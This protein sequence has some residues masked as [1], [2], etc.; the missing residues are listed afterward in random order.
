MGK[1]GQ[2]YDDS[3]RRMAVDRWIRGGKTSKEVA[4]DLGISVNSLRAWKA[5]YLSEPG[6]P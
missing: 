5:L 4:D 1:R 6:G 2:H 3:F